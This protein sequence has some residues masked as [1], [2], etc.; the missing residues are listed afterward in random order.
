M[1]MRVFLWIAALL[2]VGGSGLI[3]AYYVRHDLVE[4]ASMGAF[5][6]IATTHWRCLIRQAIIGLLTDQRLGWLAVALAVL[7]LIFRLPTWGW[8]AWF[9]APAGF[10]L[11]HAELSAPA[12][13]LA[14]VALVRA[15]HHAQNRGRGQQQPTARKR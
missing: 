10:V 11:Y 12:L 2:A 1:S 5:C 13:L 7:S 9:L 15:R 6:E 3:V 4:P 8:L 14:G